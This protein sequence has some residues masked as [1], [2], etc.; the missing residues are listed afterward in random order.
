L[1]RLRKLAALSQR[2][3]VEYPDELITPGDRNRAGGGQP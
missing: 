3:I 2:G 1:K